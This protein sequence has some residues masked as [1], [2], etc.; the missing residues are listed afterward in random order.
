MKKVLIL[1]IIA[2][3]FSAMA[4]ER[5]E[6]KREQLPISAIPAKALQSAMDTLA[7]AGKADML[8]DE[9]YNSGNWL[10]D[11]TGVPV[12]QAFCFCSFTQLIFK[13]SESQSK[14]SV[15]VDEAKRGFKV[16]EQSCL[17]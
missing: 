7:K 13:S 10:V 1:L 6:I 4:Q 3:G 2:A 15:T 8:L 9:A 5:R 11:V 12:S 17:P 14:C 16:L